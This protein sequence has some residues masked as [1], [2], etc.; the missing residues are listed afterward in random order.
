MANAEPPAPGSLHPLIG[1]TIARA[2]EL[3]QAVILATSFL[4]A[5]PGG[6]F[7]ILVLDGSNEQISL[8]NVKLLSLG[9][10]GLDEGAQWRLPMLYSAEDLTSFLKPALLLA[11]L[12]S[13]G[14][15]AAYFEVGTVIF[16]AL[17]EILSEAQGD[18]IIA[19]EA[20]RS[21]RRDLGRSFIAVGR[22]AEASLRSWS[23]RLREQGF[24]TETSKGGQT[25]SSLEAAFDSVSPSVISCPGFAVGY[26]NLN[27]KTLVWTGDH[28]E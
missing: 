10:L 14:A 15:V 22:G 13:G 16:D 26:W 7:A 6:E 21:D 4:R 1:C 2:S 20:V 17:A 8:A 9:D 12:K 3:P 23:D 19:T 28:Y 24:T 18:K 27:P 25:E 5:H 11:L